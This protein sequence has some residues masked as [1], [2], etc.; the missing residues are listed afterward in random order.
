M[1]PAA[2]AIRLNAGPK[3]GKYMTGT[4]IVHVPDKAR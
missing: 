1:R 4:D 2:R 3:C